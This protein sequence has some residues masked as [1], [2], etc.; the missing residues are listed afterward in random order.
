[1]PSGFLSIK[2]LQATSIKKILMCVCFFFFVFVFLCFFST[3]EPPH[4]KTNNVVS[5][6]V[7]HNPS[8]QAQKMA[9]DWKFWI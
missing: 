7:W 5:E 4:G 9:S 2:L 1:M 8:V 3:N 6:Q